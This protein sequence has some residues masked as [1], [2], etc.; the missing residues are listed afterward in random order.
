MQ[1][2]AEFGTGQVLWDMLWFTLFFIWIWIAITCFMD[3][4]RDH[5]LGGWGKALWLIFIIL[6][7]YLGI[8]VYLI[9]RGGGMQA[10]SMAAAQANAD[11]TRA[12]IQSVAAPA[13]PAS[14]SE[15]IA[16]LAELKDKGTISD[17]EFQALKAKALA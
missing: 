12:Y 11:A 5:E 7:P 10:R 4:F 17:E 14:A 13:G 2:L 6:T 9:A 16:R 3:I 8:F 15:E 1:T